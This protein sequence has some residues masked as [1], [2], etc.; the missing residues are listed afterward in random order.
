MARIYTPTEQAILCNYFKQERPDSLKEID[1][2]KECIGVYVHK[3]RYS[4]EF[5]LS[6]AVARIA[7]K[8]VQD[9]LPVW[10][11]VDQ[12]GDYVVARAYEHH[13]ERDT[14]LLPIYLCMINW[15][16][17]GPGFSWP[18]SY[19]LIWLPKFE[20]YVLTASQ[21]SSDCYGFEDIVIGVAP[22][23]QDRKQVCRELIIRW[24]DDQK[25]NDQEPWVSLFEAGF[26]SEEEAYSWRDEV[27]PDI[28]FEDE[29]EL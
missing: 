20:R 25:S 12:T 26:V 17:S 28:L 16:D 29:E 22:F 24:W 2:Y 11:C 13:E 19:Y 5:E 21:D 18:E 1:I 14:E 9:K 23:V 15:A 4:E 6:N 8:R 27:W 7:L 3:A 10:A